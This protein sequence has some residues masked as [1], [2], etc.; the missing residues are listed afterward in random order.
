VLPISIQGTRHVLPVD[1][2]R[3]APGAHVRVT[4]HH[5]LEAKNYADPDRKL[6]VER[7]MADVHAAIE[8]GL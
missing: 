1:G 5:A 3:T 8:G 4:I 7:L 2:M 6:A